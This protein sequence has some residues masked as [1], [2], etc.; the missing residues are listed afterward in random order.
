[1]AGIPYLHN[2]KLQCRLWR[3][4]CPTLVIRGEHDGL[5][6]A[7]HA[8]AYA[9]GIRGAKYV[10]LPDVAHMIPLEKPTELATI[11]GEF[12]AA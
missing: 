11:A 9:E 12:L 6:P 8:K 5:I 4:S 7:E 1:M 3:I 10:S 2:P